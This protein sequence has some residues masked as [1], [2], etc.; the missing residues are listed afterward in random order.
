MKIYLKKG[1]K[2]KNLKCE[3]CAFKNIQ[4]NVPWGTIYLNVAPKIE[5]MLSFE[6][7]N[8]D[9]YQEAIHWIDMCNKVRI[10]TLDW[11]LFEPGSKVIK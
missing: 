6:L 10:K 9:Q 2:K 8:I 5:Q 11:F 3:A 4:R 7:L 1:Q